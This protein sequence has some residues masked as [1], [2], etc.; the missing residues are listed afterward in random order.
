MAPADEVGE[1]TTVE[2]TICWTLTAA[3]QPVNATAKR[4]KVAC[5]MPCFYPGA[6]GPN[7]AKV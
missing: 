2:S 3:L 7:R 6:K 5:F 4:A 1:P